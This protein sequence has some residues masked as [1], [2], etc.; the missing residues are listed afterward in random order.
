M[1]APEEI[2]QGLKY[3]T[4]QL[5]G[6]NAESGSSIQSCRQTQLWIASS[7]TLGEQ[8]CSMHSVHSKTLEGLASMLADFCSIKVSYSITRTC[9]YCQSLDDVS[10]MVHNAGGAVDCCMAC[11]KAAK[12]KLLNQGILEATIAQLQVNFPKL[13]FHV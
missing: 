3:F 13:L 5:A 12:E 11:C 2:L 9:E 6:L 10:L 8:S 4:K 7:S 1:L